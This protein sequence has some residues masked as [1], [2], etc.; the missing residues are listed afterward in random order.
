MDKLEKEFA[1]GYREGRLLFWSLREAKK[2]AA[3][4]DRKGVENG[5]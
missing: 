2:H 5:N 1:L 4:R 3:R